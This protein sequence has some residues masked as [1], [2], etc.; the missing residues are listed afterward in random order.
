M[1]TLEARALE[2]A[3]A[4]RERAKLV[5]FYS[6][7][8][9]RSRRAEGFLAQVLPATPE[10][11][12]LSDRARQR[13]QAARSGR[14]VSD[15]ADADVSRDRRQPCP[16]PPERAE[17][18]PRHHVAPFA[19]ARALAV[20]HGNRPSRRAVRGQARRASTATIS[21]LCSRPRRQTRF[22][23]SAPTCAH[24]GSGRDGQ[25]WPDRREGDMVSGRGDPDGVAEPLR[26]GQLAAGFLDLVGVQPI[27]DRRVFSRERAHHSGS[28]GGRDPRR[29]VVLLRLRHSG[30]L[31]PGLSGAKT[32]RARGRRATA[33]VACGASRYAPTV[34][35]LLVPVM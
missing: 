2:E 11:R 10:P 28:C 9:G 18:L 20:D 21:I 6:P 15:R 29:E 14:E 1:T 4:P 13:R 32:C 31:I 16:R 7:T 12:D 17:G 34:R 27:G 5:L 30:H 33:R 3:D 35:T 19:L 8:S 25:L 24:P 22:A 26:R 23:S